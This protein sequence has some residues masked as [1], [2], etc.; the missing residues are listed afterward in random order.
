MTICLKEKKARINHNSIDKS[1]RFNSET[2]ALAH[3]GMLDR[4]QGLPLHSPVSAWRCPS[5]P[6][7]TSHYSYLL[8]HTPLWASIFF[9]HYLTII[10]LL[11]VPI[12][13]PL[14]SF[15]FLSPLPLILS[16]P[17]NFSIQKWWNP[18]SQQVQ[19]WNKHQENSNKNPVNNKHFFLFVVSKL[20]FHLSTPCY[21]V[22]VA[23]K[24]SLVR[25]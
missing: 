20:D 7:G 13:P 12:V 17:L 1:Y 25:L 18:K 24:W 4:L 5:L 15:L 11:I 2:P 22:S 6:K 16:S 3:S 23:A 19:K 21:Y 9:N 8:K 14:T 10:S